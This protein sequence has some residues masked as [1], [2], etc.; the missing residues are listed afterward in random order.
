MVLLRPM[1][2]RDNFYLVFNIKDLNTFFPLENFCKSMWRIVCKNM[3]LFGGVSF[4]RYPQA[5]SFC[6]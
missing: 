6:G 5:F 2:N 4:H 3:S 1:N